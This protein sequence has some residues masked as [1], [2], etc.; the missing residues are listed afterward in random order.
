MKRLSTSRLSESTI[1]EIITLYQEGR[2]KRS[3][4]SLVH[5][6]R[7]V[8]DRIINGK[9]KGLDSKIKKCPNCGGRYY[10][11]ECLVCLIR[12]KQTNGRV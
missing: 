3:I 4:A 12:D 2:S 9:S 10:T 8:I 5:V 11:K 7:P 6:S 1:R